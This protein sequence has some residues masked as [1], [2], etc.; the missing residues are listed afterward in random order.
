MQKINHS[1]FLLAL[2]LVSSI[3][4]AQVKPDTTKAIKPYVS[5]PT[6]PSLNGQYNFLLAKSK[7]SYGAKLINPVRLSSLWR[8]V[9][10]TLKKERKEL[11]TIKNNQ[12]ALS[13]SITLLK[14]EISAKD[15]SLESSVSNAD[16]IS[17]LGL[18]IDKGLY[19]LIVWSIIIIL[20]LALAFF[21]FSIGRYKNEAQHRTQLYQE[22]SDEFQ[23]H[24]A[25]AKEKE[26]RLARELQDERNKLDELRGR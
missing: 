6:D 22:V 12:T 24:K 1:Y 17:V 13:D 10:D 8:S 26:M 23:A 15:S 21:I 3:T 4:F 11:Q 2:L 14:K 20:G 5:Q 19:S 25:K 9:N 18:N 7:S 16:Q